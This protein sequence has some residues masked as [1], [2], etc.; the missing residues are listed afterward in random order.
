MS[1]ETNVQAQNL[2]RQAY[3]AL[4]QGNRSEA[5]QRAVEAARLA[6]NL[7]DPWLILAALANPTA[8]VAYL[9]KA[10]EINPDNSGVLINMAV[11]YN[12]LGNGEMGL[13][14]LRDALKL[15]PGRTRA[16]YYNMGDIYRAAGKKDQ[17]IDC[18]L[19]STDGVFARMN[20][21]VSIPISRQL[22]KFPITP[23]MVSLL[24]CNIKSNFGCIAAEMAFNINL[25]VLRPQEG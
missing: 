11:A 8:A 17:A 10:L 15:S 24:K 21:K 1:Q 2:I 3:Q 13:K 16:I 18:Y 6:P 4:R 25:S 14:V 9:N 12:R 5:R 22:I 23:N 7:E 20:R 19:K